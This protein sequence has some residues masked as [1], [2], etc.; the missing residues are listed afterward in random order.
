ML[1]SFICSILG[2]G[3]IEGLKKVLGSNDLY[4][5]IREIIY[6]IEKDFT[7]KYP[8]YDKWESFLTRENNLEMLKV[9][10]ENDNIYDGNYPEFDMNNFDG[11]FATKEQLEFLIERFRYH[12][13]QNPVISSHINYKV[14][15]DTFGLVKESLT[16]DKERLELSK[17]AIE[18]IKNIEK[19]LNERDKIDLENKPEKYVPRKVHLPDQNY[20]FTGRNDL[21]NEI[22]K[23][24]QA[25]FFVIITGFGGF[26]KTQAAVEYAYRHASEYEY[27]WYFNAN[28]EEQLKGDYREFAID[29][30]AISNVRELDFEI[31]YRRVIE[32]FRTNTS[33]LL[34]YDNA[35]NC[36][37]LKKYLPQRQQGK[38]VLINSR[39]QLKGIVAERLAATVFSDK[40]SVDF[41]QNRIG[42]LNI[43]DAHKLSKALGCLPLALEQA[44]AY[45]EKSRLSV[46]QYISQ[47]EKHGL[48]VLTA[49]PT[50]TEY[51]HTVLAVW[52]TTYKRIEEEAKD[53]EQTESALQLFKLCTYC[54]PDDIPLQLFI[55]E[56]NETHQPLSNKLDPDNEPEHV[57]LIDRLIQYSLVSFKLDNNGRALISLHQLIQKIAN[58]DFISKKDLINHCLSI[59]ETVFKFQYNTREELDKFALYLP[60]ILQIATHSQSVLYDDD[61]TQEKIA[62]I[63]NKIGLGMRYQGNYVK[64]LE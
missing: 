1:E 40:D 7:K 9:W 33:Y 59:A 10:V 6:K 35:E 63:Y 51:E 45:I 50:A 3:A 28:S 25:S 43:E 14:N 27:M 46:V 57:E 38:H 55:D 52:R 8:E 64:A 29:S 23:G 39:V 24:L 22:Y 21:L 41:L 58:D 60:H 31:I 54:A 17:E 15:I 30:L 2:S 42:G 49:I 44:A 61:D 53:D 11:T 48:K 16:L 20:N 18:S 47:L 19:Y 37:N 4:T 62:D 5:I 12:V 26:G 13:M 32:W 36:T 34:I 56:R